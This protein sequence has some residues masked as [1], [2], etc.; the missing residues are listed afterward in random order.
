MGNYFN[1]KLETMSRDEMLALQSRRLVDTVRRVYD[2]VAPYRAKMDAIGLKPEDIRSVDDLSKL[3]FTT[4]QDLR[5][6]YPYGMFAVPQ[7]EV[8]EIHA[9]SGT[10]GKQTVVGYTAKDLQTWG[11]I[12][13]RAIV[14]A[15]GSKEDYLHI[16]Y[17]YG[18]FTG[19]LGL[20][21]GGQK[22]GASVIPV[23]TG[24]TKRQIQIMQD[25][26]TTI[27]AC[28]PSYALYLGETIE[29]MGL[30][31]KL[32][33]KSGIFGAEPWTEGMRREIERRL[34]LKAHDIYGLSEIMGP[35]VAFECDEQSG[36]HVS[37]DHFIVEIIDPDTGEVLPEGSEGELV[38]TC[39]TK[40]ALPLIRYRTRDISSLSRKP[41]SCGRT[42]VKMSKP[43]GRSDDMLIIRGVNVFPSQVEAALLQLAGAG[44]AP[45]YQ[46]IVD[47]VNN[48]DTLEVQVEM[49]SNFFS[50]TVRGIEE[51]ERKI[52]KQLDYVLGISAKV[53]LV[54]PKSLARSEGKAVRVIDKRKL[55]D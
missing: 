19:G 43:R 13:A 2:H 35:G 39:V 9:S 1:E 12:A 27:L 34:G 22:M 26:G 52:A 10:T 33:L 45:Y 38:F 7:S 5:D 16:S 31:G 14:A 49:D 18:L 40:E 4:K 42:L 53:T 11:E 6:N 46:L 15:G 28:T 23:S 17:G 32:H 41:C 21:Y 51:Q 55:H 47:R 30:Q 20:H 50:D 3:P 29:E 37:E 48:L 54:E 24:N 25:F 36:M 8:A 44:T